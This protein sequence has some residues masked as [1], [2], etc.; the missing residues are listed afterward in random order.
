M[1]GFEVIVRPVVFPNI[2]PAPPRVLAP[3]DDPEEGFAVL[4]GSGG[5]LIDL[6]HSYSWNARSPKQKETSR[7]FDKERIY[8]TKD[9]GG[10]GSS[11]AVGGARSGT[12]NR[13][14]YVDVE[15]MT[16]VWLRDASGMESTIT[17]AIPPSSDNIETLQKGLIRDND[18]I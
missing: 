11:R 4:S 15:R 9:D 8:Q 5:R 1:A 2:R 12:I 7:E 3:V 16:K 17:F 10:G 14:N 6:P 13:D 18:G